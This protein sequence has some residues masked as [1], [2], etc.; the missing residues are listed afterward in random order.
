MSN[1]ITEQ[2]AEQPAPRVKRSHVTAW[3]MWAWGTAALSAVMIRFVVGTYL[4]SDACGAGDRG[5]SWL[6]AGNAMAGVIIAL[7]APVIG[8][9]ADRDGRRSLWLGVN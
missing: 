3:A 4:A 1:A 9:R 6:G 7:T 8:Q 2:T 5:T